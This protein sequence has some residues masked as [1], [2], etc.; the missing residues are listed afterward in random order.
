MPYI[1]EGPQECS[2][3]AAPTSKTSLVRS[4]SRL[5]SPRSTWYR[6]SNTALQVL[7]AR[8]WSKSRSLHR[9]R[10]EG[11]NHGAG[12]LCC[13]QHRGQKTPDCSG[14]Q[15]RARAQPVQYTVDTRKHRTNLNVPRQI[16]PNYES[17]IADL[18]LIQHNVTAQVASSRAQ[19]GQACRTHTHL[20]SIRTMTDRHMPYLDRSS[21]VFDDLQQRRP[22]AIAP[23]K[24]GLSC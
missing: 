19:Y 22:G 21:S 3:S 13:H 5:I 4:M 16:L 9:A 2:T 23:S 24:A 14:Q 11:M 15:A 6:P 1:F 8:L 7:R 17:Q 12:F 18:A 10:S 20:K